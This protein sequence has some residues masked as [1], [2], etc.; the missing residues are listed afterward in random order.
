MDRADAAG[1]K[2]DDAQRLAWLRL[3]RSDSVGPATF[4]DLIARYGNAVAALDALPELARRVGRRIRICPLEDAERELSALGVRGARLIAMVEPDYPQWLGEIDSAPPLI[5][6][7]GDDAIFA[8]PMIAIVGSCNASV[9][10]KKLAASI[11]RDLG[12]AGLVVAPG[13]ARGIDSAAHE[14]AIETG[15]VAVFAGGLDRIYPPPNTDLAERIIAGDGAHLSEAQL[16]LEPRARDFPRRNRLVSGLAL[17]VVVIEAAE[18]SGSLITARFAGEQGRTVFA[19]P[20]SPLDPRAA[21]TNRL[22]KQV[23]RW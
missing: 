6:V 11:A 8:M 1:D 18:R 15:T 3:I 22:L 19:A 2:I 20:G 14:A 7:R 13:L 12:D 10:G 16:G 17:G 4:R 9:A 21:G 5:A 23:R